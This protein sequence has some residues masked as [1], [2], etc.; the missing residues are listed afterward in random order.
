MAGDGQS[1]ERLRGD[2]RTLKPQALAML[3]A[4]LERG[5]LR[6]DD[7]AGSELILQELRHAMRAAAQPM[8][9]FGDAARMFFLPLEPFLIDARPDHKRIGRIARASLEPIWEWIVRDLMPAEEKALAED[10]HAALQ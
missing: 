1:V 4:E 2:L 10:V 5:L 3:V 6:G 8:P 7:T 9:R